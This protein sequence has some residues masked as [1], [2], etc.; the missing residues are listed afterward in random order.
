MEEIIEIVPLELKPKY[1]AIFDP[2][3]GRIKSIG[4]AAA[5]DDQRYK[6]DLDFDMAETI[7]SG[8][9]NMANYV[10]DIRSHKLELRQKINVATID[11]L[12][13]RIIEKKWSKEDYFDIFLSYSRKKNVLKIQMTEEFKGTKKL[14]RKYKDLKIRDV[15]WEGSLDLYFY[16][17]DYNDPNILYDYVKFQVQDLVGETL[18][19]ENLNVPEKFSIYTK[20]IFQNYVLEIK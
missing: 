3:S 12:V 17:T 9:D 10:V 13:H 18:T 2:E 15:I 5:F 16:I 11:D 7:V 20:R 4:P 8:N 1:V 14:P 6:V 19:F